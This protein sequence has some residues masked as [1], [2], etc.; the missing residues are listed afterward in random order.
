MT[1]IWTN[2]GSIEVS[3]LTTNEEE[4]KAPWNP[5]TPIEDLFKQLREGGSLQS[6]EIRQSVMI[7]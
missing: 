5:P 6:L 1:H 3:N 7:N 2:Y 4:M